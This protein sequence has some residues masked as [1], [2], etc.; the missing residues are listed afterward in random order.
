MYIC[1]YFAAT[2]RGGIMHTVAAKYLRVP[3]KVLHLEGATV[4][5]HEPHPSQ[6][7]SGCVPVV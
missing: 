7:E 4:V 5:P 2:A 1:G 3:L 6:E